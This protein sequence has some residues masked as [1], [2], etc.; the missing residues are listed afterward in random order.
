MTTPALINIGEAVATAEHMIEKLRAII[1]TDASLTPVTK[2]LA[3]QELD[4]MFE[5]FLVD[6]AKAVGVLQ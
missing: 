2:R 4:R 3:H 5:R 1:D 6:V